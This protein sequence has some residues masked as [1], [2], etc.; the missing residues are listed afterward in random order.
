MLD[1]LAAFIVSSLSPISTSQIS[2][3]LESIAATSWSPLG[4]KDIDL[5]GSPGVKVRIHWACSSSSAHILIVPSSEPDAKYPGLVSRENT[6][7]LILSVWPLSIRG[8]FSELASLH[9]SQTHI[10][11]SSAPDASSLPSQEKETDLKGP[12]RC[13]ISLGFRVYEF[14]FQIR[15]SRKLA[16]ARYLESGEKVREG[17]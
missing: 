16:A 14:R 13:L 12:S 11:P 3:L 4:E 17:R 15:R 6:T 5:T 7:V 10:S 1:L 8:D 2:I 9:E